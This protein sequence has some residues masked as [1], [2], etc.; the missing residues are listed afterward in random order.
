M[1]VRFYI[2]NSALGFVLVARDDYG[3]CAVLLGDSEQEVTQELLNLYPEAKSQ[4]DWD[5][6][7]SL[8]RVIDWIKNP[9]G[10]NISDLAVNTQSFTAFQAKVWSELRKLEPGETVSYRTLAR[11]IGK[12]KAF[13]AVAQACANN[14]IAIL[15]PCHRVIR[16]DGE[17]SG[18]RW[19][20]ERKRQ[21]LQ[22]EGIKI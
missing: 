16:S 5:V 7:D 15:I 9:N 17:L 11:R 1:L 13:R 10:I 14:R 19:G 18:Y 6:R 12:P 8:F 20:V 3:V 21:L 22:L 4:L 2:Q